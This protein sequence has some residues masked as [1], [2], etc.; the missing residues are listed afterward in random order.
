MALTNHPVE[1]ANR[2]VFEGDLSA[3]DPIP[4]AGI[5]AAVRLMRDGRLFRYGED[6]GSLPEATLLAR[7]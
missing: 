6:R 7:L 4:E 3:P 1:Q 2:A 5:E